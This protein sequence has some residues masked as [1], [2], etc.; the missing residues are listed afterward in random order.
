MLWH[1][2][3]FCLAVAVALATPPA[4]HSTPN[5]ALQ[6]PKNI[7]ITFSN[8]PSD[9]S[10]LNHNTNSISPRVGARPNRTPTQA[11]KNRRNDHFTVMFAR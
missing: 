11:A 3:R 6:A 8:A 9:H 5:G 1:R 10:L 2:C 4:N 7:K